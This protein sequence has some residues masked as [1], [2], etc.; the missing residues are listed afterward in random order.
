VLVLFA[1]GLTVLL[2]LGIIVIGLRFFL[3]PEAAAV[4]YGLPPSAHGPHP[5]LATKGLR[6]L[7]YG[8]LGL[9]LLIVSSPRTMGW[10]MMVTS[11]VPIGDTVIALSHGGRKSVAFGIHFA[12]AVVMLLAAGLLFAL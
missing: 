11:I 12:T 4:A 9:I 2:A 6:D 1:Y 3:T 8:V 5:Y 10:F 7:T